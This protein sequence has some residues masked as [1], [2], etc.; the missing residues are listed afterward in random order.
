[1]KRLF[2]IFLIAFLAVGCASTQKVVKKEPSPKKVSVKARDHFLKGLF[3]Q[4]QEEFEKALVEFYQ[5]LSFDS[6]SATIYNSIAENH[7]K[8]GHFESAHLLLEKALKLDPDNTQSLSLL[9]DSYFRLRD[10]DQAIATYKKLLK[11]DP[12]NE[13]ARRILIFLLE[14]NHRNEE[15]AEQYE[16]LIGMYGERRQYYEKLVEIYLQQQEYDKGSRALDKLIELDP[17]NVRAL[18]L[19]GV[20]NQHMNQPDSALVSFNQALQANPEFVMAAEQM[21]MIY[22]NRRQWDKIIEVYTP[23]LQAKDSTIARNARLTIGEAEFYLKNY[24]RA[25]ELLE[26]LTKDPDAPWGVFDLLGRIA[27]DQK[28]YDE[29]IGNFEHILQKDPQNRFG[30]LFLGFTYSDMDSLA[31]A[32]EVYAKALETI[33][34]DPALLAFYGI[35]L[36]QQEKYE[37]AVNPLERALQLDPENLNAITSLPVVY[38]NLKMTGKSDSLY[39]AAIKR[40]PDNDLLL[41]NFAYSLSERDTLLEEALRMVKK[42][43]S[44]KPDNGAYLDTIGWIYYKLGNLQEAEKYILDALDKREDSAVLYEHLGDIYYKMNKRKLAKDYWIRAFNRDPFNEKLKQK[45]ENL[46]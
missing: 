10:D 45:L 40:F 4:E 23:L 37:Q 14:K 6:T 1:M 17:G 39:R 43:L 41:N 25:K 36:Q 35:I 3:Y 19:K 18:Y 20:I 13:E 12:Y 30:W 26:P 8:L 7:I 29:A 31:K 24:K 11:I 32:E 34:D 42:A 21:S 15:L 2:I 28:N 22:R 44:L 38:E 27:L 46:P 16:Q 5:A 33:R 9:A